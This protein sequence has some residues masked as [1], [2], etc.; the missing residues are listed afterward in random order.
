MAYT[1][2]DQQVTDLVNGFGGANFADILNRLW[3][4]GIPVQQLQKALATTSN[5][6]N[7]PSDIVTRLLNSGVATIDQIKAAPQ[8]YVPQDPN[9]V[10][11]PFHPE[12]KTPDG[13]VIPITYNPPP[14]V[15]GQTGNQPQSVTNAPP[16]PP[17]TPPVAPPTKPT[18]TQTVTAPPPPKP[19]PAPQQS[20]E[21]YESQNFGGMEWVHAIPELN[22][23]VQNADK[24]RWTSEEFV[25]QLHNTDWWKQTQPSIRDFESLQASDPA[26]FSQ[27]VSNNASLVK[28]YA[29]TQGVQLSDADA[30]S[31]GSD[32]LKF[33]WNDQ[34]MHAAVMGKATAGSTGGALGAE[35][36]KI[37]GLGK[38]FLTNV[39]DTQA[40]QWAQDIAAGR[41]DESTVT[42]ALRSQAKA[43]YPSLS[44]YIDSGGVPTNYF[45]NQINAA[46]QL[47]EVDPSTID[48]TSPK[49]SQ[50]V[51]YADPTSGKVRPMTQSE[52]ERFV[53]NTDDYWKTDGAQQQVDSMVSTIG[54]I[55]GKSA[56]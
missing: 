43:S 36:D 33:G 28:L 25:A 10:T 50:I 22:T 53:K 8:S 29:G 19:T 32:M 34:Q 11:W 35:V 14:Q 31:M 17:V 23:L 46:A 5:G 52:T 18:T 2:H 27:K 51:S 49:F 6:T 4:N 26:Q 7:D 16:A 39:N 30:Q 54:S 13:V 37:K 38:Q 44:D 48:L 55:F 45:S 40:M 21:Q 1:K 15:P 41:Y 47:L 12:S 9:S 42:Q 20:V 3:M 56:M 24:Y